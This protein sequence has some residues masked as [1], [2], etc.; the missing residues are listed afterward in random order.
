[1]VSVKA[2]AAV[3]LS[4]L[5]DRLS[6]P[7]K[8]TRWKAAKAIKGLIEQE[9][10]REDAT[11]ALLRWIA[12]AR[13]ESEVASGLS[14]LLV[15]APDARPSLETLCGHIA[16]PSLLSDLLIEKVYDGRHCGGWRG[17]HSGWPP[18]YFVASKYFE[19]HK[20]AQVPR[21]FSHN[22]E[23]LDE[24]FELPFMRQWAY[25]WQRLTDETQTAR[26]GYPS[27]FG[28]YGQE[29]SGIVGQFV[30]RQGEVYRSAYLRM[31]AFAVSTW[32]MPSRIA[33]TY[34]FD[35]FSVLPDLFDVEPR[36]RPQWLSDL[37][38]R[39]LAENADLKRLGRRIVKA[40]TDGDDC[41]VALGTPLPVGLAEFGDLALSAFF[42]TDDFVPSE[43]QALYPVGDNFRPDDL[44]F[45]AKLQSLEPSEITG[46][47]GK[48]ISVCSQAQ[49]VYHGFWHDDYFQRGLLLPAKY[50]FEETAIQCA[51]AEGLKLVVGG[52]VVART[53]YWHDAWTPL[54]APENPTRCGVSVMMQ[55][56]RL[57]A[58]VKRLG[59][60]IGWRV[61]LD[62]MQKSGRWT[63]RLRRRATLP[64]RYVS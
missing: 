21:I 51:D 37:P 17:A 47:S 43:E 29:R 4:M 10:T 22:V 50:C 63:E 24:R 58:A 61:Q 3:A 14:V 35:T 18:E 2:D 16:K 56:D 46:R 13:F 60:K 32:G 6:W 33:G 23:Y 25:E 59:M 40:G 39:C 41:L 31:L 8:L 64:A 27:Y 55:R 62:V 57:D 20:M 44:R 28:D 1:M 5:M 42:V 53:E 54:S 45:N 36:E 12:E 30:Q 9:S 11:R 7:V 48:A 19:D 49:P 34:L 52:Q 15:T 38:A 26:T